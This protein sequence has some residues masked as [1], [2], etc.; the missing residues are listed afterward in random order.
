MRDDV[1]DQVRR[2][3]RHAASP[4]RRAKA[5]ALAREGDQFVVAAVA[6]VQAQ[7][8]VGQDA[9]LQEGVELVLHKLRQIGTSGG[10]SQPGSE[11]RRARLGP[12]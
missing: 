7:E 1:V 8:A 9:A 5:S 12:P 3:L 11:Q 4:T 2:C 6:A 10:L